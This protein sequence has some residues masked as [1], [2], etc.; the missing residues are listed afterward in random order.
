M[1]SP[2]FLFGSSASR[3]LFAATATVLVACG[4]TDPVVK[5]CTDQCLAASGC[6]SA[7]D[8]CPDL[9]ET[10]RELSLHIEC[11]TEYETM[12]DCMDGAADVCD[13]F[14]W[15]PDEVS[16][17]FACYGD[18]CAAHLDDSE[19]GQVEQGGSAPQGE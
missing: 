3:V 2:H 8:N 11:G 15:C 18:F 7:A 16:A 1:H 13:Q 10:E 6:P 4:P 5:Q 9:C 12:L 14:G 19:C 17:Y